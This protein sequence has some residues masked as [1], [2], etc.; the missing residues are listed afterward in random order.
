M[1]CL[2][3]DSEKVPDFTTWRLNVPGASNWAQ[4]LTVKLGGGGGAS[5]LGQPTVPETTQWSQQLKEDGKNGQTQKQKR[6]GELAD[7]LTLNT[8]RV[9]GEEEGDTQ[10]RKLLLQAHLMFWVTSG[11]RNKGQEV[12]AA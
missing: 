1:H 11:L 6:T 7:G 8:N 12:A 9:A 10:G 5:V 2:L 4:R 3:R